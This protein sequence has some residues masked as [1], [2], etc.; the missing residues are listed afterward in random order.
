MHSSPR[1]GNRSSLLDAV[2]NLLFPPH[3]VGCGVHGVWLCPVCLDQVLFY[4]PPWPAFFEEAQ[5]LLGARAAAHLSGPLREA[6]HRF[7]YAGL[8]A[9]AVDLGEMLY[10]AWDAEPWP[11]DVVV[12]VPLH[13]RRLRERGYN[14][15][16]LLARELSRRTGLPV[17]ERTLQ[18][19]TPTPP[20]VG[21]SASQ[22]AANVQGAFRCGDEGLR[23]RSVLLIDDVMTTGATLR[24]CGEALL[25]GQ[26]RAVWGLTVAH[27]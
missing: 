1:H 16:A 14:Q 27:D 17:V 13:P 3:C 4:E 10:D 20:Q 11:V 24:A 18:R 9:L 23:G 19:I 8:R 21:L 7:K 25:D 2:L 6:L 22:R 15:S 26:A 5:P 12:P